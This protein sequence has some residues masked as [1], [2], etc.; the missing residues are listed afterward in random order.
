MALRV[1]LADESASI[2]KAIQLSLQD[3]DLDLKSL[4]FG[5]DVLNIARSFKPDIIFVDILLQKRNGY[6]VCQDLKAAH[7][8]AH[9]PVVLLWS[10]FMNIDNN[11]LQSVQ[12][13]AKIEKPFDSK[14][15]RDLVHK[16]VPKTMSNDLSEFLDLPE[17][18]GE[19][20]AV[21]T[22]LPK[23]ENTN[24]QNNKP[25]NF[26]WNMDQFENPPIPGLNSDLPDLN[27]NISPLSK[28]Q[29]HDEEFAQVKLFQVQSPLGEKNSFAQNPAT[30]NKN[31]STNETWANKSVSKFQIQIPTDDLA[32][33]AEDDKIEDTSFL[34]SP[35]D[36]TNTNIKP[37]TSI[38]EEKTSIQTNVTSLQETK[39][40]L[41]S[42]SS[43]NLQNDKSMEFQKLLDNDDDD[44]VSS[45]ALTSGSSRKQDLHRE[46]YEQKSKINDASL[47]A[48]IPKLSEEQLE[49]LIR[50]QSRDIIE[51]VVWKIVP[52][53][54]SQMIR[55]ELERLL[56]EKDNI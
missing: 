51:K 33:K 31:N 44:E 22:Q 4:S 19:Y 14:L 23:F 11:K 50:E 1:L 17:I 20:T 8:L 3:F 47:M 45:L 42:I 36:A 34:W 56:K 7:D 37:I 27:L 12:A 38:A 40:D 16:L 13:D 25:A 41:T 53:L 54:A 48:N 24:A 5:I 52:D 43:A 2:K 9:I 30:A 26:N 29:D 15:L 10:G 49:Q 28:D 55:K 46:I 6:E 32:T 39:I 35:K 21:N 18:P